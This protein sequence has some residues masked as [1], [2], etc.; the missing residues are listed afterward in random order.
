[1]AVGMLF[2]VAT[3]LR[4]TELLKLTVGQIVEPT[5]QGVPHWSLLLFPVD[6]G[7][8]SKTG[9]MD[10]GVTLD[11]PEVQFLTPMLVEL[12]TLPP[13]TAIVD[14]SYLE[15]FAAFRAT[16]AELGI[17]LLPSQGRHSGA[18]MD[19]A[20][21][22]RS[23]AEV[24]RMGRWLAAKSVRRYEKRNRLNVSWCS[25]SAAQQRHCLDCQAAAKDVFYHGKVMNLPRLLSSV[26]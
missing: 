22:R 12:K 5:R 24:Q 8:R 11:C 25:L 13:D 3:Y 15:F 1:M 16:A 21:D 4:V 7:D 17:P 19:R 14:M 18:S 2:G 10:E 20:Y 6:R 9:Q 23:Q 26:I